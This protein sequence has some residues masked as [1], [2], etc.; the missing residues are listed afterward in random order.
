MPQISKRELRRLQKEH[1]TDAKIGQTFG[2][3]RQAIQQLRFKYGIPAISNKNEK[4][5]KNIVRMY[6]SRKRVTNIAKEFHL[7]ISQIYRIINETW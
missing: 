4:R 6:K 2:V 5:N 1:K 3:T 7:S